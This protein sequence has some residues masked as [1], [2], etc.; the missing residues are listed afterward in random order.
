MILLPFPR[1]AG[2]WKWIEGHWAPMEGKRARKNGWVVSSISARTLTL[3]L[4]HAVHEPSLL[5]AFVCSPH[6]HTPPCSRRLWS[7]FVVAP[8]HFAKTLGI[9][10]SS[11]RSIT[12]L[13][14]ADP[15]DTRGI[16][17][18]TAQKEK[19]ARDGIKSRAGCLLQMWLPCAWPDSS[20]NAGR[21]WDYGYTLKSEL[22]E[23]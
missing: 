1:V 6:G 2:N 5:C 23:F 15:W 3:D 14:Y 21:C 18:A 11:L 4:A 19:G 13:Q 8:S 12:C 9:Q 10:F 22:I 20:R 7:A 16:N 17:M